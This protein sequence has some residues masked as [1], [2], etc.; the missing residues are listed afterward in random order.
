MWEDIKEAAERYL[1]PGEYVTFLGHEWSGTSDVGGDHNV[2]TTADDMPF[3]RSYLRYNYR[4]LRHYHGPGRQSGHVEDLF[5]TLAGNF[6]DENLLTIP[7]YG[8]RP[9]NPE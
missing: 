7:H 3:V 6:R 2:Y 4:N 5:R 1:R 9:G 8:G